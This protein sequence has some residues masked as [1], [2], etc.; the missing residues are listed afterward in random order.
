M[1]AIYDYPYVG[2]DYRNDLEMPIP[3][4]SAYKNIYI[5]FLFF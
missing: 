3:P 1:V 2:I 4:S 5:I